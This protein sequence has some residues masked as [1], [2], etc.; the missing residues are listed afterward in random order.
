MMRRGYDQFFSKAKKV[1][2]ARS[3]GTHELNLRKSKMKLKQSRAKNSG[4]KK[5]KTM[6]IT[7]SIGICA[8][9]AGM[10]YYEEI[11]KLISRVEIGLFAQASAQSNEA[12]ANS[13]KAATTKEKSGSS[14]TDGKV[15]SN[16]DAE[17]NLEA[18]ADTQGNEDLSY[19]FK[20]NE[21]KKELDN[22]EKEIA[23]MEKNLEAQRADLENR[24]RELEKVRS[25]ISNV[26]EE[27]V[28]T[29]KAKID[30]LVQVYSNMRPPQAA[31]VF[32]SIDEDLAVEI[33]GK[34][35][36]KNAADIMNLLKPDKAQILSEKYAGYKRK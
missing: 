5:S 1:A 25:Q 30:N 23:E 28:L 24:M 6:I 32:E 27:K 22:R 13:E 10:S 29:D 15:A 7:L 3:A 26:L 31:K 21:R 34:M 16:T 9:I 11:D 20:L 19:A 12:S 2:E 17:K 8:A 36:K 18:S 33:L 4:T 35:K 14:N